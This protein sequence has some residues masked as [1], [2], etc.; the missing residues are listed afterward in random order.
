MRR[1]QKTRRVSCGLPSLRHLGVELLEV[2]VSLLEL[3]HAALQISVK[4]PPL[5]IQLPHRLLQLSLSDRLLLQED[6]Q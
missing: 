1:C 3:V 6:G 5:C 4:L 2:L